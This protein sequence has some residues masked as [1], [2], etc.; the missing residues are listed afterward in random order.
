MELR[1]QILL[2]EL[3]QKNLYLARDGRL[4][5]QLTLQELEVERVRLPEIIALKQTEASP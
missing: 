4:L 2:Q 5:D 3:K 1:R